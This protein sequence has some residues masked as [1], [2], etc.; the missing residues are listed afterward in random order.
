MADQEVLRARSELLKALADP[1]RLEIIELLR[2]GEM[3]VCEI[4][5]HLG[6]SQST[7][8]KNLDILHRVGVLG[9]RMDGKRTLYKIKSEKTFAVLRG[10]DA[11]NLERY[12]EASKT[13]KT[14]GRMM[15]RG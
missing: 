6:R 4:I 2:G 7:T 3:C 8:S 11:M 12:G 10:L 14:L 13:A 15:E 9:R 5:P 1:K